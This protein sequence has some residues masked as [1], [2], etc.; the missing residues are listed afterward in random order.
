[1]R[2]IRWMAQATAAAMLLVATM[3]GADDV[4]RADPPVQTLK[5]ERIVVAPK[6]IAPQ[7]TEAEAS[8]DV[9][10]IQA[11][12]AAGANVSK[13]WIGVGCGE[14]PAALRAHV[15]VPEGEGLLIASVLPEGP[16]AKAGLK[17]Y[18]ILL[19]ADGRPLGKVAELVRV[20][21]QS[22]GKAIPLAFLRAGKRQ[23]VEVTPAER[24]EKLAGAAAPNQ[25]HWLWQSPLSGPGRGPMQLRFFHP[26]MIL[27]PGSPAHPALP[28]NMSISI[29]K[30]GGEP[31]RIVVKRD[32]E[33]WEVTEKDVDKLPE[34]VQPHVRRMLDGAVL[35]PDMTMP[36]FD[37]MPDAFAPPDVS[38]R[39]SESQERLRQEIKRTMD[40][41]MERMEKQMR[42][43]E[44]QMEKLRNLP[45]PEEEEAP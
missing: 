4:N 2:G 38:G 43:L 3:A 21:D 26:G 23:T 18:D 19:E 39:F 5:P 8:N 41:H 13:Y 17:Q 20:I 37:F 45:G 10:V 30:Q 34:D 35:G 44:E 27:P 28:G 40:K 6:A 36:R 15:D 1:M 22:E 14:L 42:A 11:P 29:T 9:V 7:M 12:E 24:T 16:A 25:G 31:A 33:T 32:N